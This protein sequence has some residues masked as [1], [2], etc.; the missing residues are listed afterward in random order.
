MSRPRLRHSKTRSSTAEPDY[1]HVPYSSPT[2]RTRTVT[3]K[4]RIYASNG[5]RFI[6]GVQG[7]LPVPSGQVGL[8][9]RPLWSSEDSSNIDDI[10]STQQV[11]T[12]ETIDLPPESVHH[13]KRAAQHTRWNNEVIPKLVRPYM[14]LLRN[15]QN[16]RDEVH[17]NQAGCTC[18][19]NSRQLSIIVLRFNSEWKYIYWCKPQLIRP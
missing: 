5:R 7:H 17:S 19:C 15:T 16:L 8:L 12:F 4:P 2:K 9:E 14:H 3:A 11:S 6:Q 10:H 18:M 1:S 13:R